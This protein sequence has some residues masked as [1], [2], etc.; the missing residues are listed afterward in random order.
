M[1]S[2]SGERLQVTT[3]WRADQNFFHDTP[4]VETH[5]LDLH[6]HNRCDFRRQFTCVADFFFC[7]WFFP[8]TWRRFRE[9]GE[10]LSRASQAIVCEDGIR[11]MVT[12]LNPR[13]IEELCSPWFYSIS[14]IKQILLA[15]Y[16]VVC[17]LLTVIVAAFVVFTDHTFIIWKQRL[18]FLL[19]CP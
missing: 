14:H 16:H 18:F 12:F 7:S 17:F 5:W 8:E 10:G 4:P 1:P 13:Q 2:Y 11:E 9:E 19:L 6:G 15:P 3:S